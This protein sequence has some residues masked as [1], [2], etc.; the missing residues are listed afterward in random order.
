[1][2]GQVEQNVG[3]LSAIALALLSFLGVVIR[4]I[5]SLL[6]RGDEPTL[7]ELTR[8]IDRIDAD[9]NEI[10][11]TLQAVRD[12]VRDATNRLSK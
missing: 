10:R 3:T 4:E 12:A 2:L 7:G 5:I 11:R 6:R 9:N 8:R 1:M